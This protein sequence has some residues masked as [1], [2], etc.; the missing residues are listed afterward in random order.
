MHF[1]LYKRHWSWASILSPLRDPRFSAVASFYVF[2]SRR[3]ARKIFLPPSPPP[4]PILG[5]LRLVPPEFQWKT[6]SKWGKTVGDF[7]YISLLGKPVVILNSV[8]AVHDLLDKKAGIYS[9]RPRFILHAELF[10]L[11]TFM[12]FMRNGQNFRDQRRLM[13]L[14]LC[15]QAILDYRPTQLVQV[16]RFLKNVLY[17]PERF[18]DHVH[19]LSASTL[20]LATYGHEIKSDDDQIYR[21]AREMAKKTE[22][23]VPGA[24][25]PDL[26]PILKYLPS[27]IPG[28][29][30]QKV[31]ME[32]STL[33]RKFIDIPFGEVENR[34][35]SGTA[36]PSLVTRMLDDYEAKQIKDE[37]HEMN[38][39]NAA[40]VLYIA[41]V[42]SSEDVLMSFL[43]MMTRHPE[44]VERAQNEI[45]SVLGS[46]RLPNLD[47]RPNL[48]FVEC[49]LKEVYRFNPP[50]PL[51]IPHSNYKEDTYRGC[52]IPQGSMV[53]P[54][55]WQMMRDERYFIKP[56]KFDP[57]RFYS[58]ICQS[59]SNSQSFIGVSRTAP[60][61]PSSLIFGFG[62]R[63]CPGR[64][65]ADANAWLVIAN[66][67]AVFRIRPPV[68]P[69]TGESIIPELKFSCGITS[70]PK[71]FNYVITPRSE[72]HVSLIVNSS[73][74]P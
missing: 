14:Q 17:S 19:R 47:D 6:F 73:P 42:E 72:K 11:T 5:H 21:L 18:I 74:V 53:I 61:N 33:A 8:E 36:I 22:I 64:Y 51:A 25:I 13:Q 46:E 10:K 69:T 41:G 59:I 29:S 27:W 62:R 35:N 54:N 7:I 32:V 48:P 44:F 50:L 31:A 52:T 45:D 23:G 24:T 56:E 34:R 65:F 1:H 63:I 40:A 55:I 71:P 2:T 68:D 15:S 67:L 12:P 20:V 70:K 66:L 57:E 60:D 26:I 37:I 39:K 43:L 9:D 28:A 16:H 30:F 49:V 4:E 3:W 38:M 58:S